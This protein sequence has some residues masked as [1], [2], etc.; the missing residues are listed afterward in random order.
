MLLLLAAGTGLGT[1][2]AAW[3]DRP[4]GAVKSGLGLVI[5]TLAQRRKVMQAERL[6]RDLFEPLAYLDYCHLLGAGGIRA[7][8]GFATLITAGS[9]HRGPTVR[10]VHRRHY[11]YA[12]G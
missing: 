2:N 10:H 8:L 11:Q 4:P 7:S 3:A 12:E 1:M 5:Y 9:S 6:K